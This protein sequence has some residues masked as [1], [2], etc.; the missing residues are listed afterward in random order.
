VLLDLPLQSGL[1][2]V[3]VG[4]AQPVRGALHSAGDLIGHVGHPVRLIGDHADAST[5]RRGAR[6]LTATRRLLAKPFGARLERIGQRV[7]QAAGLIPHRRACIGELFLCRAHRIARAIG[8]AG[9]LAARVAREA[10]IRRSRI[11]TRSGAATR[12]SAEA[13]GPGRVGSLRAGL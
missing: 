11:A 12:A 13:A 5:G 3:E 2:A 1:Q 7:L 8:D 9:G 10:R 4:V 6:G